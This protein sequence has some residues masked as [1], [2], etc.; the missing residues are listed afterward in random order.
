MADTVAVTVSDALGGTTTFTAV[1]PIYATNTAP[2]LT[3]GVR[4]PGANIL[5]IYTYTSWT[6][7]FGTDGD[8]DSLSYTITQQP[9]H[10]SASYDPVFQTLSTTGTQTGDT[11]VLTVYDGYY[12]VNNGV[13]S[14]TPSSFSNTYTAQQNL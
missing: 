3:D 5:G 14:S 7:V 9:A 6:S 10:G 13:V 12:V 8:G 2:S 11:I 4:L 1:I